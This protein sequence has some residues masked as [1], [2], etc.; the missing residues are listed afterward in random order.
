MVLFLKAFLIF[1]TKKLEHS[2]VHILADKPQITL[3]TPTGH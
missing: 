2:D 1:G 3:D